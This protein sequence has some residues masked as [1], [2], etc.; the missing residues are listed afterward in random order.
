MT[1]PTPALSSLEGKV[2]IVTGGTQGVGEAIAREFAARGLKGLVICGRQMDKGAEVA[3]QLSALGCKTLFVIADLAKVEEAQYVVRACDDVFRRVDILVNAAGITDRGN[4]FD[5]TPDL[6]DR[7]FAIN[8]RAPFFLMQAAVKIMKREAIE[9]SIIN[10]Q[11]MSA[12]GGQ[13]FIAAY[14]A[15]KGALATLTK[16]TANALLRHRIRVNGLNI[17]WMNTPGEDRIMKTY[18]GAK[19]GWLDEAVKT[20]PFGRLVDPKEVARACAYLASAESGLLT[21]ANIDFDQMVA[22][23]SDPAL[24]PEVDYENIEP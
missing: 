21:G 23:T 17:G 24:D 4:I 1:S 14:C 9:G 15:S 7:M 22:G 16:N 5:T 18:H 10:I 13:A 8:V 20:R 12:H 19:D 3:E 6:F 2:A 11:S